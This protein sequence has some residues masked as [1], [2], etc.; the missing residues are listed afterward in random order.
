M[1]I[2]GELPWTGEFSASAFIKISVENISEVTASEGDG[3]VN[4]MDR[5]LRKAL[6][7]FYPEIS[8]IRLTDYKV[9]VLDTQATASQVRVLIETTDSKEI[10]STIGVS[11]DILEASW[12]ALVDSLEYKLMKS[13]INSEK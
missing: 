4:A 8:Q 11:T 10:W 9:R 3:P 6:E 12:I 7:V 5:A 1:R 13:Q 2:S